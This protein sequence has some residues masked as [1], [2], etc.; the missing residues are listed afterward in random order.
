MAHT[1]GPWK[2]TPDGDIVYAT[3][4]KQVCYPLS[5]LDGE[6]EANAQLIAAAPELLAACEVLLSGWD[7]D[8]AC[9]GNQLAPEEKWNLM[10][11]AER[12]IAKA[13]GVTP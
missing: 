11:Q 7:K 12:A 10:A 2:P 13:K 8:A 1:P 4:G 6:R 5:G 9:G 3:N